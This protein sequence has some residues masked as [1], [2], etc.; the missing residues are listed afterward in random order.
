M[1]LTR[2]ARRKPVLSVE[3]VLEKLQVMEERLLAGGL[4]AIPAPSLPAAPPPV[5]RPAV[6][7]EVEEA[8]EEA[9]G[10]PEAAGPAEEAVGET[11]GGLSGESQESWKEFV[12]FAKKK[13]PPFAS[14]LEHGRPLILE[15]NRLEVGYP[16][17]SFYLE[18]MQETDNLN[19]L[20]NL[21][22]EF[23][24]RKLRVKV[25]GVNPGALPRGP[26]PESPA[27]KKNS[28][29]EKEEEALNHPLVRDAINVFGGRVVEI[30]NR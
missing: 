15:E 22:Q 12:S 6:P 13:K 26:V 28:K 7:E 18:R 5:K 1:T 27:E 20:Q 16:E 14:L 9:E 25:T 2:V 11:A 23:F 10:V 19:F 4:T 8:E 17:K 3:E 29:R 24:K 21:S 30:K